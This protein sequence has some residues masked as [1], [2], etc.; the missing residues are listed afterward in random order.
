ML[1]RMRTDD[2]D[3]IRGQAQESKETLVIRWVGSFE[4]AMP[5]A[6][7]LVGESRGAEKFDPFLAIHVADLL[8]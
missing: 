7:V 2:G 6:Q 4:I 3:L 1:P 5:S 8:K